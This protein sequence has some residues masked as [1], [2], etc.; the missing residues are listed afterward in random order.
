MAVGAAAGVGRSAAKPEVGAMAAPMTEP[1]TEPVATM[2]T[3]HQ[4]PEC[5]TLLM[6][7]EPAPFSLRFTMI[8]QC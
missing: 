6:P 3:A 2:Q 1:I 8:Q 7:C 5:Q 4:P